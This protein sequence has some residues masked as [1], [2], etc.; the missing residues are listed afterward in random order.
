M[1]LYVKTAA[2]RTI[3]L[4]GLRHWRQTLFSTTA[5]SYRENVRPF[6][7]PKVDYAAK[8][9]SRLQRRAEE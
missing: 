6:T 5:H 8:Y 7:P 4:S 1:S 9:A 2:A 3:R